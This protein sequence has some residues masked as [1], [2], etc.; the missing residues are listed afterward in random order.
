MAGDD[1]QKFANL[2]L[3]YGA[4]FGEPGKKLLFQGCEIA[5]WREWAHE[6]S[7]DWHLLEQPKHAEILKWVGDLN[8]LY[9]SAPALHEGD[10]EPR[11][12]QWIEAGDAARS[13]LSYLRYPITG[14]PSVAV[15]LNF[16]PV[17]RYDY[18]LGVPTA[19][20]WIERLNSDASVY[21]GSG[22]GNMGRVETSTEP[23]NGQPYSL[24]LTLPPL[25]ALF[26]QAPSDD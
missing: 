24:R 11:G 6:Q 23:A 21:G 13:V 19:G 25:G 10:C 18:R 5:Q 12:F 16:T 22:I 9:R 1:W 3:L 14:G 15:V 8:A 20:T 17:P 4:M 2:R 7:L 26:L